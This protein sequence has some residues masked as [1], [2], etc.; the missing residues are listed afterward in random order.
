MIWLTA[1][2]IIALRS[3]EKFKWRKFS[4]G[5]EGKIL[6]VLAKLKLIYE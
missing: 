6:L 2:L 1:A 5:S 4:S 3:M